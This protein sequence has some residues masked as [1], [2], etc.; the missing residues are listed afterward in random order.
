MKK[1]AFLTFL[2]KSKRRESIALN[3]PF[4]AIPIVFL[5]QFLTFSRLLSM[6]FLNF[7]HFRPDSPNYQTDRSTC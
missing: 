5:Q 7:T 1:G 3:H 2:S 4:G 6:D